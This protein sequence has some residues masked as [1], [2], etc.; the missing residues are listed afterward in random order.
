MEDFWCDI[1]EINHDSKTKIG[2]EH[3]LWLL[4][5]AA[6]LPRIKNRTLNNRKK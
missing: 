1:C 6:E 2:Q 5:G 3:L 4:L